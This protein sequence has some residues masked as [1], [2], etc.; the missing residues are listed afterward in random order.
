MLESTSQLEISLSNEFT[1]PVAEVSQ[2]ALEK[3]LLNAR[4]IRERFSENV[5]TYLNHYFITRPH[6]IKMDGL[7]G[8]DIFKERLS[9][10]PHHIFNKMI[11]CEISRLTKSYQ[12]ITDNVL[13]FKDLVCSFEKTSK[14]A[15][16]NTQQCRDKQTATDRFA[17]AIDGMRWDLIVNEINSKAENLEAQGKQQ[18]ADSI[19]SNMGLIRYRDDIAT[20][21]KV[22]KRHIICNV[23][24]YRW[25]CDTDLDSSTNSTL[26]ALHKHLKLMAIDTDDETLVPCLTEM[27]KDDYRN[28]IGEIGHVYGDKNGNHI[29]MHK[30]SMKLTFTHNSFEQLMVWLMTHAQ[31]KI[32]A[33][34]PLA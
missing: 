15:W 28:Y 23:R 20:N 34:P 25:S 1:S 26:F 11:D 6:L 10:A 24:V 29:R 19:I 22:T 14:V 18:S 31:K 12:G 21:V 9:S 30:E 7:A 13:Q 4:V 3:R 8:G 27:K 32:A 16:P 17:A 33:L 2:D 5:N